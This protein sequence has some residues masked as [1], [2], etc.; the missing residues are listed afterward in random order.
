MGNEENKN[1]IKSIGI[2]AKSVFFPNV[3]C[4]CVPLPDRPFHNF[5]ASKSG[6][7]QTLRSPELSIG[8]F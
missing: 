7:Q 5:R 8:G 4:F 1:P 3:D 2:A 6:D